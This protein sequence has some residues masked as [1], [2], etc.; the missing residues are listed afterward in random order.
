[1]FTWLK[2]KFS[3]IGSHMTT[4]LILF[5]M[6]AIGCIIY[7]YNEHESKMSRATVLSE[8]QASDIN[9][10][11]NTIK[12]LNKEN[13]E[14]LASKVIDVNAGKIKPVDTF[15]VTAQSP[16][17]AAVDV[18][19]R[20]NSHDVTLPPSALEP[21]DITLIYP[22]LL[23]SKEQ[24]KAKDTGQNTQYGVNVIKSN[25]YKGWYWSYG[26]GVHEGDWYVPVG[27][28]RNFDKNHAAEVKVHVE[29]EG[30]TPSDMKI[31]GGEIN[32]KIAT[33]K[34]FILF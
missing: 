4:I 2:D 3:F 19:N 24:Q 8:Q 21:T 7:Q 14:I 11:R 12:N 32:Y 9:V 1:M 16:E 29:P 13:A 15:T 28:Q 33:N 10:L 5:L 34:P 30:I 6:L 22:H 25:N 27:L 20:I 23:N 31:R 18:G 26:L 17:Q